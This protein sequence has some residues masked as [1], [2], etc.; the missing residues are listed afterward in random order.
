MG[1][2]RDGLAGLV[3]AREDVLAYCVV[4]VLRNVGDLDPVLAP[5]S[6]RFDSVTMFFS[7]TDPVTATAP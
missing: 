5:M 4:L 1:S 2:N 3:L 6:Q 7:M